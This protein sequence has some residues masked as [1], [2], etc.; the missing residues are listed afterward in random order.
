MPDRI[1]EK[2]TSR[3]GMESPL[4]GGLNSDQRDVHKEIW[5]ICDAYE[6]LLQIYAKGMEGGSAFREN[7]LVRQ[8]APGRPGWKELSFPVFGA[9]AGAFM[10]TILGIKLPGIVSVVISLVCAVAGGGAGIGI[11][12]AR[13]NGKAEHTKEVWES[14][15]SGENMQPERQTL[16]EN[17][18]QNGEAAAADQII[19]SAENLLQLTGRLS[20]PRDTG[21]D[22]TQDTHFAKWVQKV[23]AAVWKGDDRHLKV[24]VTDELDTRLS[25]MGLF[26][27]TEPDFEGG[28]LSAPYDRLF[29]VKQKGLEE[30]KVVFPAICVG[31]EALVKGEIWI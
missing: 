17:D 16:S 14:A 21:Y 11:T 7:I 9:A 26:V 29:L 25:E 27:C 20:Q 28:R 10:G 22:I 24:L 31:E 1:S 30:P 6:E 4:Y 15:G 12:R 3:M 8:N 5:R 13:W 23:M 2:L 19:S 18:L